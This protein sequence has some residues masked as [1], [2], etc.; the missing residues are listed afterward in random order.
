MNEISLNTDFEDMSSSTTTAI[1]TITATTTS[2]S[3]YLLNNSTTNVLNLKEILQLFNCAISQEQ[4]WAV[5][6]QTLNALKFLFKSNLNLIKLNVDNIA[7]HLLFFNKDGNVLFSFKNDSSM[8]LNVNDLID[9]SNLEQERPVLETKA[10]KSVAYLIFDALDYGNNYHNEPV[11]NATLSHLLLLISGHFKE[12]S[13]SNSSN[14]KANEDEGYEQDEEES[15]SIEKALETCVNNINEADK[16][17]QAV[18][19]GLYS[20]AFELKAFLAKIEDSKLVLQRSGQDMSNHY[21]FEVLDTKDWANLWMQVIHELRNGVKLRKVREIADVNHVYELTPF[22]ILLDQIRARRYHLK[23]VTRE[24]LLGPE[25]KKDAR[26][27]ILEFIRSRPP[28]KKS[29][30]RGAKTIKPKALNQHEKLM[31]SIRNLQITLRKTPPPPPSPSQSSINKETGQL[32][33]QKRRL[34]KADKRLVSHLTCSDTDSD[35]D[36]DLTDYYEYEEARLAT[37]ESIYA[38]NNATLNEI[39]RNLTQQ[40]QKRRIKPP[41]SL[42]SPLAPWQPPVEDWKSLITDDMLN[43]SQ[44]PTRRHT[45]TIADIKNFSSSIFAGFGGGDKSQRVQAAAAAAAT[46]VVVADNRSLNLNRRQTKK[47]KNSSDCLNLTFDELC[48]I[49]NV[50]T[51]A[52]LD[53]LLFDDQLFQD[54][55]KGKI[56]FSCRKTKFNLFNWGC[57]CRICQQKICKKCLRNAQLKNGQIAQVPLFKLCP[58]K[59]EKE[60]SPK[61]NNN[62]NNNNNNLKCYN[63]N[64]S[65]SSS[66]STTTASSLNDENNQEIVV[67]GDDLDLDEAVDSDQEDEEELSSEYESERNQ[68]LI[69]QKRASSSDY[70]VIPTWPPTNGEDQLEILDICVDC[71][72]MMEGVTVNNKSGQKAAPKRQQHSKT[73]NIIIKSDTLMMSSLSSVSIKDSS[74]PLKVN[75]QLLTDS[76]EEKQQLTKNLRNN[77]TLNLQ[78]VYTSSSSSSSSS[79]QSSDS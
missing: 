28:L 53:Y 58:T 66:Q 25:I 75:S 52:E 6:Y 39:L 24:D 17:Y 68:F 41:E 31:A 12:Y 46:V 1:S 22:E 26:D 43:L 9:D 21:C 19:R 79:S 50:L 60:L 34:L 65:I 14:N 67:L 49:R 77:L 3:T 8:N 27:I 5:L 20:Q 62:N 32:Q 10:L 23:K 70:S 7:I 18:C 45:M 56:C 63:S 51:K 71:Y 47:L 64:S 29:S 2:P 11:L 57:K 15:M 78:P 16:H 4:A 37:T 61:I 54:V 72:Q 59:F 33:T 42:K 48:H 76:N 35:S 36:T 74:T 38:R 13:S 55:S 40:Q 73:E 44:K 30:L 69:T